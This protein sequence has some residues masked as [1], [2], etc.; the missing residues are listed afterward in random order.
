MDLWSGLFAAL[1]GGLIGSV[2]GALMTHRFMRDLQERDFRRRE[3]QALR[4]L[5]VELENNE[6]L[7]FGVIARSDPSVRS[8]FRRSVW[9]TQLP[10]IAGRLDP[11][12]VGTI[13]LA[14]YNID[15][16]NRDPSTASRNDVLS[17]TVD[18]LRQ[19]A[20]TVRRAAG[21]PE[22]PGR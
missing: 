21:L 14:Y 16:L 15:A 19:A 10:L 12:A 13:D 11:T 8:R 7:V 20:A 6:K 1:I 2:V 3:Y 18:F 9:D 17:S 22:Q 4:A 5:L